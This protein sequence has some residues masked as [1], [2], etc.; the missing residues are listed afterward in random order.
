[1]PHGSTD[2]VDQIKSLKDK[3]QSNK[4]EECSEKM[5][6]DA[7]VNADD[8]VKSDPESCTA[9]ETA[10][11]DMQAA[12]IVEGGNDL[13]NVTVSDVNPEKKI[14]RESNYGNS[15]L[16]LNPESNSS[17]N[18]PTDS[19]S[20]QAVQEKHSENLSPEKCP[21]KSEF[22][23]RKLKSVLLRGK[24]KTDLVTEDTAPNTPQDT[25]PCLKKSKGADTESEALTCN[26]KNTPTTNAVVTEVQKVQPV[27]PLFAFA[28]GLTPKVI[29]ENLKKTEDQ[30]SKQKTDTAKTQEQMIQDKQPQILHRASS[31]F[32]RR[33]RIKTLKKH[34]SISAECIKKKC[35]LCFCN[36]KVWNACFLSDMCNLFCHV[37][38]KLTPFLTLSFP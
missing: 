6:L 27:D 34:Q 18:E 37:Q 3:L 23:L 5:L 17:N 38:D 2:F 25:E 19:V 1:M 14:S 30:D 26:D 33:G 12:N 11:E 7:P 13:Q 24:R 16:P 4:N 35:K 28:L 9:P 31:I 29:P 21:T 10:V 15:S 32:T 20:S 8:V 36:Y 22:L